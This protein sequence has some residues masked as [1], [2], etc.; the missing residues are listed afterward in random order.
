MTSG[1]GRRSRAE[2]QT[3]T[4]VIHSRNGSGSPLPVTPGAFGRQARPQQILKGR[5]PRPAVVKSAWPDGCA[6]G[7]S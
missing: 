7:Q 6:P 5:H 2:L 3:G 1:L 4:W